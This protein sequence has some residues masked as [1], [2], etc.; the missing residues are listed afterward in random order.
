ML[1]DHSNLDFEPIEATD[2]RRAERKRI[3]RMYSACFNTEAGQLVLNDLAQKFLTKSI[4][5]PN[6]DLIQIGIREGKADLVR[7]LLEQL[8]ISKGIK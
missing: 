2:T 3:A 5:R 8:Q 6:D 7:Q 4:A 1:L